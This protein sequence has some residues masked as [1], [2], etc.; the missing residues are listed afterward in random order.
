MDCNFIHEARPVNYDRPK[1]AVEEFTKEMTEQGLG[2][3]MTK[4]VDL[5]DAEPSM[6][7]EIRKKMLMMVAT[8]LA[9]KKTKELTWHTLRPHKRT[10]HSLLQVFSKSP[11]LNDQ[12]LFCFS[13]FIQQPTTMCFSSVLQL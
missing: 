12:V 2:G 13:L 4:V 10:I 8:N 11:M 7:E 9:N 5:T 1:V 6:D 3:D